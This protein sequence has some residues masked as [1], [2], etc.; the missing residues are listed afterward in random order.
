MHLAV[1][2]AVWFVTSAFFNDCTPRLLSSFTGVGGQGVDVTVVELCITCA[3]GSAGLLFSGSALLPPARLY[4]PLALAGCLHLGGCRLFMLSLGYIPVAL[5]QTIRAANPLFVV[6]IGGVFQGQK[7]P[8]RVLACLV[9]I[10]GGFS[11]AVSADSELDP[12]GVAAS[13]GSVLCLVVVNTLSK[14]MLSGGG[15]SDSGD[16]A[17]NQVQFWLCS[18]AVILL[19][20][21][22]AFEGGAPRLAGVFQGE[23][24]SAVMLLCALDGTLYFSEQ[25]VQLKVL[26]PSSSAVRVADPL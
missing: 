17:S 7:Y 6:L 24:A 16:V 2:L 14:K 21:Q 25:V 15:D 13:V 8:L 4:K 26:P 12:L 19:L 1:I 3:I 11:L 22:W 5:A 9:P 23:T 18:V 20:P 10:V